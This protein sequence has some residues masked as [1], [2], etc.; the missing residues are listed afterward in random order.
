MPGLSKRHLLL[1]FLPCL[2]FGGIQSCGG[3]AKPE[4]FSGCLYGAPEPV[5]HAGL[6]SVK[7]HSF[8]LDGDKAEEE[9]SF[10]DGLRLSLI[11]SGCD[12]IRQEFHFHL[13]GNFR[14][15]PEEFWA[16][17]AARIFN[18]LGQIGPEYLS[19]RSLAQAISQNTSQIRLGESMALQEGFYFKMEVIFSSA[20]AVLLITLSEHS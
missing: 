15:A 8:R 12:H 11:Q 17:E 19:Y 7:A 9:L 13:A 1:I 20:E 3:P 4:P 6:P 10:S 5:F 2:F 16:G 18:R 14:S